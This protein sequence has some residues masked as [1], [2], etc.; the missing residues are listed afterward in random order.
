VALPIQSPDSIVWSEVGVEDRCA[1]TMKVCTLGLRRRDIH[2]EAE[3]V[4][5]TSRVEAKA[6]GERVSAS[7]RREENLFAR[8]G[9]R[10]GSE[11]WRRYILYVYAIFG[12]LFWGS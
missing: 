6:V 4:D 11:V 3:N 9:K 7:R 2:V 5:S 8:R 10:S 12:C 1:T